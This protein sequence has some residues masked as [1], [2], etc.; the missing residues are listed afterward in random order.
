MFI[1]PDSLIPVIEKIYP[2]KALMSAV[3][4]ILIS[5]MGYFLLAELTIAQIFVA[6]IFGMYIY[7]LILA[8]YPDELMKVSGEIVKNKQKAWLPLFIFLL[9]AIWV[10]Y[11]VL[12]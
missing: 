6:A 5:V 11:S 3:L 7:G 1:K 9:L 8:Q 4:L 10:L 2:K 12:S